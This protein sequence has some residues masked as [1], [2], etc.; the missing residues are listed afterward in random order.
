MPGCLVPCRNEALHQ[1]EDGFV[2][3]DVDHLPAPAVSSALM[4]RHHGAERA[5]EGGERISDRHAHP[6]RQSARLAGEVS[7]ATHRL[8]DH[9]ESR[10]VAVGSRLAVPGHAHQHQSG[11]GSREVIIPSFQASSVPA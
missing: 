11:V 1:V 6:H 2:E 10:T 7:K 5:V 8:A 3:R 9:A 4:E